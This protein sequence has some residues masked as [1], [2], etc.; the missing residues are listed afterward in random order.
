MQS[1]VRVPVTQGDGPPFRVR[2]Q[3]FASCP[4]VATGGRLTTLVIG[5]HVIAGIAAIGC[6]LAIGFAPSVPGW[7]RPLAIASAAL[8]AAAFAVFWDGQSRL[9]FEEGGIGAVVSVILFTTAILFP[10][11]FR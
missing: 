9:L 2:P 5:L 10:A 7:W 4:S 1:W 8:G 3:R 11:A 6:A